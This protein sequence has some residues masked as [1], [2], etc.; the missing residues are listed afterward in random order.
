MRLV[1]MLRIAVEN[2]ILT[3]ITDHARSIHLSLRFASDNL[4]SQFNAL[5]FTLL[6]KF[7]ELF[8]HDR[9]G[10]HLVP[11]NANPARPVCELPIMMRS[12]K[13]CSRL[14]SS[15]HAKRF[16]GTVAFMVPLEPT[17]KTHD[18]SP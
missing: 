1:K 4:A 10:G 13:S 12:C 11:A 8:S 7:S 18:G 6:K 14:S 15:R 5:L 2:L 3:E 9:R 17:F 16:L